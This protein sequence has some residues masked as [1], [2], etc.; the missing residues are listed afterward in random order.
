MKVSIILMLVLTSAAYGQQRSLPFDA[1]L[2]LPGSAGTVTLP[3][4]EYNHL[5]ELATS[6]PKTPEGAPLPFVLSRAAFKLR[7]ED[8][9][10]LGAVEIDGALLEKGSVT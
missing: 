2:P 10:L 3:L 6:K 1:S 8:Q 4:A 7:V 5:V 9:T